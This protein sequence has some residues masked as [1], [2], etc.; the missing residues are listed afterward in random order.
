MDI[1]KF[2]RLVE[3]LE[4]LLTLNFGMMNQPVYPA[5]HLISPQLTLIEFYQPLVL[6]KAHWFSMVFLVLDQRENKH[7]LH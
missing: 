7:S 3:A 5:I 2:K 6:E 1:Y 4:A